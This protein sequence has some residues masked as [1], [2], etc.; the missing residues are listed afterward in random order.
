MR[1]ALNGLENEAGAIVQLPSLFNFYLYPCTRQWFAFNVVLKLM[2]DNWA[3]PARLATRRFPFHLMPLPSRVAPSQKN[4]A[5]VNLEKNGCLCKKMPE[6]LHPKQTCRGQK[7]N[8]L[9]ESFVFTA[10]QQMRVCGR[11][12]LRPFQPNRS[13]VCQ[14]FL[15][16]LGQ[17]AE[18]VLNSQFLAAKDCQLCLTVAL[19]ASGSKCLQSMQQ[20]DL[21][22]SICLGS[23]VQC[24]LKSPLRRVW[25]LVAGLIFAGNLNVLSDE[26]QRKINGAVKFGDTH[27]VEVSL[28]WWK[29]PANNPAC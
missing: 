20:S 9:W 1:P 21:S 13:F 26:V 23:C 4:A 18:L 5:S 24:K 25:W 2:K 22:S 11:D 29:F 8:F 27:F 3:C 17:W 12:R 7:R 15:I 14:I 6:R 28:K 10:I 19:L 16:L